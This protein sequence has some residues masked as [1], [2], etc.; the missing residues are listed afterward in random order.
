MKT[1]K[2]V[3]TRSFREEEEVMV[4]VEAKTPHEA[5]DLA[6]E[7]VAEHNQTVDDAPVPWESVTDDYYRYDGEVING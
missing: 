5:V 1:F 3:V 7:R 2:V 6:I 4:E